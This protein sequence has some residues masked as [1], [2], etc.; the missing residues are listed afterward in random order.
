MAA[1]LRFGVCATG[2]SPLDF[3][4][5]QQ[6]IWLSERMHDDAAAA[7]QL[8]RALP[9]ASHELWFRFHAAAWTAPLSGGDIPTWAASAGTAPVFRPAAT[10]KLLSLASAASRAAVV[11]RPAVLL[12]LRL[13]ARGVRRGARLNAAANAGS[14]QFPACADRQA[15]HTLTL[16][17]LLAYAEAFP[18]LGHAAALLSSSAALRMP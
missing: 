9:A 2:R 8:K 15:V 7:L 13:A 6:I 11:E 17:L 18:P 16:Q 5:L 14:A 12:Q 3:A 4:P 10:V 1:L